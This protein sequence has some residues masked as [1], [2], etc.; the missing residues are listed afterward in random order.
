MSEF[1]VLEVRGGVGCITLSRPQAMNALSLG[2]VR[3]L[4][5]ALRQWQADPSVRAIA[6]RGSDKSGPFG[7]FCA[8]GDIRFFHQVALAGTPELEDFFTEEY[9]LNHL[10]HHLGKPLITF[11][12]GIVFGGGMG[13]C[14]G[15]TH[16]L[17]TA[18]TKMAMPETLIGL[19]ADVGGGYFLSR[20]PG[21]AGE[22]LALTG[23]SIRAQQ[24]IALGLA[25]N[26]IDAAKQ[27]LAW[28]ALGTVNWQEPEALGKWLLQFTESNDAYKT[29]PNS[30]E[31][32]LINRHFTRPSVQ[33]ILLSLESDS[34]PWAQETAAGLRKRS[35]LML[36]VALE[37][38]RK[39]RD[40]TLA[41]DLRMERDMVRHC[42][43]STHLGRHGA[44]TETVEG[45]RALVIDKDQKPIWNPSRVEEVTSG[46]VEP[47]FQSPWPAFAHPLK[48]LA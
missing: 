33:E 35:P 14:Q 19:F 11:L 9:A 30:H 43:H 18:N 23:Q 46:M 44:A 1:L 29:Y 38:V 40:M 21:A 42:F 4:L 10:T 48:D 2:M 47:F 6:I 8:G 22:W 28:E 5:D 13:L 32:E 27:S 37:H 7:N 12:D 41:E 45:I 16:R 31:W 36:H 17:V 39:A 34:D 20:C 3:G 26:H 24:A 15:A 25:D